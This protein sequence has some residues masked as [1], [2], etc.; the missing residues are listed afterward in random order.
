MYSCG[1]KI[2]PAVNWG[3]FKKYLMSVQGCWKNR[4]DIGR[5]KEWIRLLRLEGRQEVKSEREEEQILR[6]PSVGTGWDMRQ[7]KEVML[8][9]FQR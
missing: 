8:V 9:Q 4:L 2:I 3:W 5:Q 7:V 1:I 6:I